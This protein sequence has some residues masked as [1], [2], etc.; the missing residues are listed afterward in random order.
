MNNFK[1]LYDSIF[2]NTKLVSNKSYLFLDIDGV[3]NSAACVEQWFKERGGKTEENKLLFTKTFNNNVELVFPE[4]VHILN[5]F[6]NETQIKVVLISTWRLLPQYNT[7]EKA[8]ENLGKLGVETTNFIGLTPNLRHGISSPA[9]RTS[10]ILR[11]LKE[12]N[13][14]KTS[15][16]I[17]LD[18][19]FIDT[20]R[21]KKSGYTNCLFEQPSMKYGIKESNLK[22]M[23][24]FLNN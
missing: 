15:K 21:V 5:R 2:A 16:L 19:G 8:K 18:D 23:F 9:N 7:L 20:D 4:L 12:N 22:N 13:I 1:K 17:I 10:E 6:L 11:W 24:K 3:L 14:F